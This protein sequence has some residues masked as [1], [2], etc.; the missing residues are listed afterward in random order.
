MNN[1]S[2]KDFLKNVA[3][4]IAV[5]GALQRNNIYSVP[6]YDRRR[7]EFRLKLRGELQKVVDSISKPNYNSKDHCQMIMG[8]SKKISSK[9]FEILKAKT[10]N[11]GTS[12]KLINLYWKMLWLFDEDV[13]EPVHCPFDGK[14]I[15]ML[16]HEYWT[17]WTEIN[18]ITV[19]E[20]LV[21]GATKITE[22]KMSIAQW[23][24]TAYNRI[25]HGSKDEVI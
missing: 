24:L 9:H 17:N 23:E 18:C 3:L 16:D 4:N 15:K 2:K 22:N 5:N 8:F 14:I 6:I 25:I 11:I 7:K 1:E 20:N 21:L 12:Q 19:Y 13:R 10:L